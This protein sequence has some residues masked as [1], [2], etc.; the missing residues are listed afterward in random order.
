MTYVV[1]DLAKQFEKDSGNTELVISSLVVRND[2]PE[3]A[4]KVNQTNIVLKSNCI[5]FKQSNIFR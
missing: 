2:G 1:T 5:Y 3:L 4:K